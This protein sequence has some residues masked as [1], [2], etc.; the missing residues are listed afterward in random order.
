MDHT[1]SPGAGESLWPYNLFKAVLSGPDL[2]VEEAIAED[3][4]VVLRVKINGT[5]GA[6]KVSAHGVEVLCIK[7]G[8]ITDRWAVFD[9]P[10]M[11]R[12]GE[13]KATPG[14]RTLQNDETEEGRSG[15]VSGR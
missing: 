9:A 12:R 2:E 13:S 4:S 11:A 8:R 14:A 6:S 7:E 5:R 1:T 3:A 15:D 10:N